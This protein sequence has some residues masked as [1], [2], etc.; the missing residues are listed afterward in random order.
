MTEVDNTH[1]VL[2]SFLRALSVKVS[3]ST[4]SHLLD[5]PVGSSMRGI[6]DALDALRIRNEV[7]QLPPTA[8]YF[9]QVEAPFITMLLVDRN[10]FRVVTKK[11]DSIV[12]FAHSGRMSVDNF[13]KKWTG[14][15]LFGEITEETHSDKFY[16]WKDIFYYLMKYKVVI[17]I[18][19][20]IA[21]G[22]F[23][24][25]QKNSSFT[26][27]AYLGTLAFGIL[28][29]V[30]IIYKELFNG[31]F[32]EHFCHIGSTVDCNLVLHS[33]GA[34]IAGAS[35]GELSLLYFS[36]MFLFCIIRPIDFYGITAVS[37]LATIGFSIYSVIYQVFILRKGCM[38]CM[39]VNLTIWFSAFILYFLNT[40]FAINI[41]I[42]SLFVFIALGCVCLIL[43]IVFNNF[44][45]GYKERLLYR[46][47]LLSLFNSETFYSLLKLEPQLKTEI[48]FTDIAINNMNDG[49]ERL[50]IVTNPNCK[51][52]A[53][54]HSYIKALASEVPISLLLLTYPNDKIGKKISEV[55]IATYLQDGW[56]KAMLLLGEWF[57]KQKIKNIDGY[58]ITA[59]VEETRKAQ[60][61]YCW[62]QGINRTPS[63]YI[64][65]HQLPEVYPLSSLRYVLT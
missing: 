55:I 64:N 16:L 15:V 41:T 46:E 36:V 61:V 1:F 2:W 37:N 34:S 44:Q 38:L 40:Y 58:M 21:L 8:E 47:R 19:L 13:L 42:S 50:L 25:L 22:L 6:S 54:A 10:P 32:L 7:Y 60:M 49:E 4:L 51:N 56:E 31:E 62:K 11:T 9:S 28:V 33:K 5:T 12:E 63:V 52:C 65:G 57:D 48:P 27:A 17:A 30:A 35:L 20:V 39:I 26:L 59:E 18:F 23:S 53:N 45:R 14:T 24:S 3:R 43:K 29:S